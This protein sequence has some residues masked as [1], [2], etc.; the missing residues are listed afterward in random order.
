MSG[1][2]EIGATRE[3]GTFW[4]RLVRGVH[5]I[6]QR[7]DWPALVGTDWPERIMAMPVTDRF[8]AKQGR[9]T[10]RWV[11]DA[12][13]GRPAVY[14]KRHYRLPRWRGLLATLCPGRGW[15]PALEEW[16]HLGT[17]R[18][19]GL[20]VPERVAAAEYIGPW[21]RLQSL[22]A[23]ADLTGM[24][25]LHE[26]VPAA[27]ERLPPRVFA[28]WKRGLI[29]ELARLVRALHDQFFFHKD[30][31]LCHFYIPSGHVTGAS[32]GWRGTVH[33]IDFHRLARHRRMAWLW[34]AKD[35][36]QLLYS[37][38]VRGVSIRD[39]W[40]FWRCYWG[41]RL[42]TRR[43]KWLRPLVLFKW[44]GYQRHNARKKL[45]GAARHCTINQGQLDA[46]AGSPIPGS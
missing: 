33:V 39:R 40:R 45:R 6:H 28:P 18:A 32:T 11:I 15:S 27:A 34:Q 44:R 31:Y 26:A 7:P 17:A 1:T 38:D 42:G 8:H 5:R 24:L 19:L 25:P 20:P 37:S 16:H 30:L 46:Y 9:T 2:A 3:P 10:G 14:L 12:E 21:G 22:L 4:Q 35:L 41:P 23:I 29:Q 13:R 36:A 43:E